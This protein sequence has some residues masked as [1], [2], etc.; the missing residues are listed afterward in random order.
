MCPCVSWS[1]VRGSNE[2]LGMGNRV[3]RYAGHTEVGG[4][5]VVGRAGEPGSKTEIQDLGQNIRTHGSL[6]R[7]VTGSLAEERSSPRYSQAVL[8]GN[9]G[10]YSWVTGP[11]AQR[12]ADSECT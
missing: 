1:G 5:Q 2:Q 12:E 7:G 3:V 4:S 10:F 11:S 9:L 8:R 6:C